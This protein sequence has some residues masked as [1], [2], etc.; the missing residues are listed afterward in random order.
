MLYLRS[1]ELLPN[2][3]RHFAV[4]IADGM[5]FICVI[6]G[7]VTPR[8]AIVHGDAVSLEDAVLAQRLIHLSGAGATGRRLSPLA[9]RL[10]FSRHCTTLRS[11]REA[12]H[13]VKLCVQSPFHLANSSCSC[14]TTLR[15]L[16]TCVQIRH[17]DWVGIVS[18]TASAAMILSGIV[19]V[20]L[21][22]SNSPK[23]IGLLVAGFATLVFF[24]LWETFVSR[25]KGC[26]T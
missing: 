21:L 12:F 25:S 2:R 14:S 24:C 13:G 15:Y 6:A 9:S 4:V 26:S 3:W 1:P 18:F 17:L 8:I 16:L 7:P 20:Q 11:I 22:P 23:V 10:P 5:A 19:Y